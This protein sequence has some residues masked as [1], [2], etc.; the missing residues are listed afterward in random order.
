MD[1]YLKL[2]IRIDKKL[3]T[4]DS[5]FCEVCSCEMIDLVK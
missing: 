2:K 5:R 1:F 3:N 4:V